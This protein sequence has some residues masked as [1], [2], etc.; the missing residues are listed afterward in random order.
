M[1]G[2]IQFTQAKLMAA[3]L[4]GEPVEDNEAAQ[5][6]PIANA[7]KPL[8]PLAPKNVVQL[9][10]ARLKDVKKELRRMQGLEKERAQ[11]ERL[12]NAAE[13][14]TPRLAAIKRSAG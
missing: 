12:I 5:I 11:L 2:P 9:A 3:M 13:D 8:K 14:K 1:S 7:R 6:A 10:K 4:G